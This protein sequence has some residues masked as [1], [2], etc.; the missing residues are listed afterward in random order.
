MLFSKRLGLAFMLNPRAGS[1]SIKE[2]LEPV[3]FSYPLI[4]CDEEPYFK[5][6]PTYSECVE[7]FPN[8]TGYKIFS[9][10]R[11]PLDR[12]VSGLRHFC[13]YQSDGLNRDSSSDFAV[14]RMF[15]WDPAKK[16]P[17][18]KG[19]IFA[20]QTNWFSDAVEP[21]AFPDFSVRLREIVRMDGTACARIGKYN[22]TLSAFQ[23]PPSNA[24]QEF[25]RERFAED[26]V[27]GRRL[28][29]LD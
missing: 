13:A 5:W 19:E 18:L 29:L 1:T 11:D 15:G 25:V 12:F 3:G 2:Y 27:L 26:Y 22:L 14:E 10:F 8:L 16:L 21:I 20:P 7:R 23:G 6:H 24:V 4:K 9:V 28:G 17:G